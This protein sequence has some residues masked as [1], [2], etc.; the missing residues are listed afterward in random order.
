MASATSRPFASSE[1]SGGFHR[2]E[3]GGLF[4]DLQQRRRAVHAGA[5]GLV[6][7]L[8]DARGAESLH[9]PLGGRER[10]LELPLDAPNRAVR[11]LGEEVHQ[12]QGRLGRAGQLVLPA[13]HQRIDTLGSA[14]GI[15]RLTGHT[16]QEILQPR[17]PLAPRVHPLQ[18]L[19]V[20]G[21][22]RL[23]EGAQVQ[24]RRGQDFPLHQKERDEQ[25][26]NASVAVDERVDGLELDVRSEEHTSELQSLAYL[27]C[28]L[29]LEKKKTSKTRKITQSA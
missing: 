26:A 17:L 22:R 6:D 15:L 13:S 20:V 5:L 28:R 14:Q 9:C 8:E 12:L 4:Q 27:V 21:A 1:P 29:L 7:L 2:D 23:E 16:V 18:P 10:D 3:A 11:V 25:A 19:I 24:K